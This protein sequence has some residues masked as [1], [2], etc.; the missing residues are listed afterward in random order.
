[1]DIDPRKL[2]MASGPFGRNVAQPAN[3]LKRQVI[4]FDVSVDDP[5]HL[6]LEQPSHELNEGRPFVNVGGRVVKTDDGFVEQVV[7]FFAPAPPVSGLVGRLSPLPF[8]ASDI[9]LVC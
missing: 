4:L 5:A 1:M 2:E 8:G 9:L 7:V 6:R 3:G